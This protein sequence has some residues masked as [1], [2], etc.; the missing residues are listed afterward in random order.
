MA[1]LLL[2]G[3]TASG[4]SRLA[5]EL[6]QRH[7]AVVLSADAM[8]IYRRLSVGTAKPTE[9]E[10]R[11]V[12]HYGIDI[13]NPDEPFDVSNFVDLATEVVA[14]HPRVIIAGGTTFWL[15]ALVRP[16]AELPAS[17][18]EVRA[19]FDAME[20]PHAR[21]SEIDPEAAERLHPNDRLRV[22]RALEVHALSGKSQTELHRQGPRHKALECETAWMD[23]DDVYDRIDARVEA[24]LQGAYLDEIKELLDE[25]LSDQVK[26]FRSF[27]YRHMIEH[28]QGTLEL[29][30]AARRTARDTRH[31]AKKQRTW[32]RNLSWQAVDEKSIKAQA[33][34][35]FR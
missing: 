11:G 2:A 15:S 7:E 30:E 29:D 16:L 1:V 4:K 31:Y 9:A 12:P 5:I 22:V 19:R 25:G 35:L 6:A 3:T 10:M 26:P 13:R 8:T 17:Q 32:A 21:L 20:N 14:D 23:R 27:A 18:P 28:L 34:R 33:K 24:M